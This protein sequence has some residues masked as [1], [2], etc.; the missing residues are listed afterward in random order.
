MLFPSVAY[1]F[2]YFSV[3][4]LLHHL[5][6][7]FNHHAIESFFR[8]CAFTS[9][10]LFLL[11]FPSLSHPVVLTYVS[12]YPSW[13]ALP[14]SVLSCCSETSGPRLINL[15]RVAW[16][17]CRIAQV[18]ISSNG[19]AHTASAQSSNLLRGRARCELGPRRYCQARIRSAESIGGGLT[20]L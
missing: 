9:T 13:L 12:S 18:L 11:P 8:V 5:P 19:A 20:S 2:A 15:A 16:G 10:C 4:H 7:S 6:S 3:L 17:S 1:V 14:A